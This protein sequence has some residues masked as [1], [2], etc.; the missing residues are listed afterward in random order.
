MKKCIKRIVYLMI[1]IGFVF[2]L[3]SCKDKVTIT[4]LKVKDGTMITLYEKDDSVIF[5]DLVV[6]VCY[7]NGEEDA[8]EYPSEGLIVSHLSTATIGTKKVIITYKDRSIQVDVNVVESIPVYLVN[9]QINELPKIDDLTSSYESVISDI[10]SAYDELSDLEKEKIT[11]YSKLLLSEERVNEII[12]REYKELKKSQLANY[13][14]RDDYNDE[15]WE[16]IQEMISMGIDAIDDPYVSVKWHVDYLYD[17]VISWLDEPLHYDVETY[18]EKI[19]IINEGVKQTSDGEN[20]V[21]IEYDESNPYFIIERKIYPSYA[22]NKQLSYSCDQ[23]S[24]IA[25][26]DCNIGLVTF[27][28]KGSITVYINS[29]D[30]SG[31]STSL[32]I[33]AR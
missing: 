28:K 21:I 31:V 3:I 24:E 8:I 13:K 9:K 14:S 12:L 27:K 15:D 32:T 17:L 26:V 30:G 1:C 2:S 4:S 5:E 16:K 25:T 23:S 22:S 20:Y 33:I 18:I 19:E 6:I 11:D 7:S 10:R 29:T